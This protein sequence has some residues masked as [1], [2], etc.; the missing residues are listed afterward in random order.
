MKVTQLKST[1]SGNAVPNQF[2]IT[3]GSKVFFQSYKSMIC[4]IDTV[5]NIVYLD[6][7]YWD[8]SRTTIK[9]LKEFLY[10][11]AYY[12]NLSTDEIRT[13]IKTKEIKLTNLNK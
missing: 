2:E 9:Y 13:K 4:K 3:N 11:N 12:G 10:L 8:Y 6:S 1:R 7:Y 5:K